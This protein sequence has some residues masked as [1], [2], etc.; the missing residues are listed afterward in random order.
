MSDIGR[1]AIFALITNG[2]EKIIRNEQNYLTKLTGNTLALGFP[3]HITLKGRFLASKKI[4]IDFMKKANLSS[5]CLETRVG[6]SKPQYIGSGLSWLEILPD[7]LGFSSLL[8]LHS[9]LEIE[10]SRIL[11][12]DEVPE[13]HKNIYFRPHVT[14]GWSVTPEV[15]HEYAATTKFGSTQIQISHIALACYHQRWP[16]EES[17]TSVF[18]IPLR[19]DAVFDEYAESDRESDER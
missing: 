19:G 15:W 9:F 2:D 6:L 5:L 16:L 10:V 13:T 12:I 4:I 7:T 18:K 11:M 14:L 1:F 3:V 8:S 17:V